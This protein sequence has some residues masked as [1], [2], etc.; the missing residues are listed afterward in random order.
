MRQES[1]LDGVAFW[2]FSAVGR[3]SE[4]MRLN[5]SFCPPDTIREGV[6]R[7]GVVLKRHIKD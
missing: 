5:F 1:F 2:A 7:L 6:R 3:G 4:S